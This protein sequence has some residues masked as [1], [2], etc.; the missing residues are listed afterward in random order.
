MIGAGVAVILSVVV[1]SNIVIITIT[2]VVFPLWFRR[3]CV[4]LY[5]QRLERLLSPTGGSCRI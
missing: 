5:N 4:K 2:S 3:C 1:L